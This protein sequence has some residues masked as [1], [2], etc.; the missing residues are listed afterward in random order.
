MRFDPDEEPTR[1]DATGSSSALM[2]A[3]LFDQLP[4]LEQKRLTRFVEA[5]FVL[6]LDEKILLEELAF[7]LAR[8]SAG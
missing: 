6:G 7:R 2:I 8:K 3:R 4:P 5:W 1:P